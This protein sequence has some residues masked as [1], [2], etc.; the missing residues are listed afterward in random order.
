MRS[1]SSGRP[2]SGSKACASARARR[3]ISALPLRAAPDHVR[4]EADDRVAAAHRAALDRFQQE[5]VGPPVGQLEIGRDRRLEVGDQLGPDELRLAGVVGRGEGVEVGR[6]RHRL[7]TA[8]AAAGRPRR[9]PPRR[10]SRRTWC[11]ARRRAAAIRSLADH[12][13]ELLAEALERVLV[14]GE[15]GRLD[16]LEPDDHAAFG[17]AHRLQPCPAAS[18]NSCC[19][20]G[21]VR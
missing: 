6:D 15:V 11:A 8:A 2:S 4:L 12:A 18:L 13:V 19:T 10:P 1:V 20:T 14:L 7:L 16:L 5:G 9:T 21:W 17:A 3:L